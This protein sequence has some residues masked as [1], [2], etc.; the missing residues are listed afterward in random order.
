MS[1]DARK[2]WQRSQSALKSARRN[3]VI[4]EAT[5]C[6]RA[7]YAA[8]YAVSALFTLEGKRFKRHTGVE[9]A[10]HRDLVNAGR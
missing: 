6:N 4:D 7:Y 9:A 5:A 8:F 1:D 10:V 3:V 2:Y